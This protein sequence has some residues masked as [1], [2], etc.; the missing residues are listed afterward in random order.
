MP[1]S[2]RLDLRRLQ[3]D[4]AAATRATGLAP[5]GKPATGLMDLVR[6]NLDALVALQRVEGRTWDAIAAGL[7]A[8]GFTTAD[9]RTLTGTNL[10]GVISSVRRQMRRR[11]D[12]QAAREARADVPSGSAPPA[13]RPAHP[14]AGDRPRLAPELQPREPTPITEDAPLSEAEIRKLQAERHGHLFNKD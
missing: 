7:S 12:R 11:A 9:G 6:E 3:R 8:Q 5:G 4:T 14:S 2:P 10:T 13:R 1:K